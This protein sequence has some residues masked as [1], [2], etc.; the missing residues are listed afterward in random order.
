MSLVIVT[1]TAITT[2]PVLVTATASLFG[3]PATVTSNVFTTVV[4]LPGQTITVFPPPITAGEPQFMPL[5]QDS[6]LPQPLY[7]VTVTEIDAFVQ[8]PG[9]TIWTTIF[10]DETANAVA[11]TPTSWNEPYTPGEEVLVL[12]DLNSGWNSWSTGERAGLC[13]GVVL[14]VLGLLLLWWCCLDRRQ[15]WIVQPR[16]SYWNGGYWGAGLRGGGGRWNIRQIVLKWNKTENPEGDNA[17]RAEEAE[18]DRSNHRAWQTNVQRRSVRALY[19][20][21]AGFLDGNRNNGGPGKAGKQTSRAQHAENASS[22]ESEA[23]KET[24]ERH[25]GEPLLFHQ[26]SRNDSVG[27]YSESAPN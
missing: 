27:K 15:E 24:S 14:V 16:G 26:P 23:Q 12:P 21:R 19:E 22:E 7:T 2:V 11:P 18:E 1:A 25:L 10:Y 13:A 6:A 9:G 20:S 8:A 4:G 17:E 3:Q 5:V